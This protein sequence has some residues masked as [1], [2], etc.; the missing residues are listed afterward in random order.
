MPDSL[1]VHPYLMRASRFQFQI[2]HR[3]RFAELALK[4]AANA[5]R[6]PRRTSAWHD[7]LPRPDRR[8]PADGPVDHSS[9]PSKSADN[10]RDIP[11]VNFA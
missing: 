7:R 2:N 3:Q 10:H 5:K 11:P 6:S 1:H 8:M 9:S 4:P